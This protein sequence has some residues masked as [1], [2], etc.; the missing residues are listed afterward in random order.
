MR[1]I[2]R[3]SAGFVV[4]IVVGLIV[5]AAGTATAAR[6]ITG[7]DIKDGTITSADIKNATIKGED[8][9][10]GTIGEMSLA[11]SVKS[12]LN[13]GGPQGPKGETGQQGA[14]GSPGATGPK[15]DPG[16]QGPKG[17]PGVAAPGGFIIKDGDGNAVSGFVSVEYD[18]FARVVD[19]GLWQYRW[20]GALMKR[21][22]YFPNSDC[23][24]T[25]QEVFD[26]SIPPNPQHRVYGEND[27]A[28]RYG[29]NPPAVVT[30]QSYFS[31]VGC[32]NQ[33]VQYPKVELVPVDAP[34]VL[35]GPLT[36]YANP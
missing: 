3:S 32:V 9:K 30:S 10:T 8:I 1:Q 18:L 5:A 36:V 16:T 21:T 35:K 2:F 20:D 12:K 6:M 14:T 26:S 15:G 11:D 29:T 22:I 34:P 7:A 17:D 28:Y 27:Q 13:T 25:P 19:G 23:T 24:G 4:L 31:S 33:T